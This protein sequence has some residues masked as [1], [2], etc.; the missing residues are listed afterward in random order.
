MNPSDIANCRHLKWWNVNDHS[1]NSCT[2]VGKGFIFGHPASVLPSCLETPP[3]RQP[4][5]EEEEW[6]STHSGQGRRG[7]GSSGSFQ[8]LK[9]DQEHQV[10]VHQGWVHR[11]TKL[12]PLASAQGP[13]LG[14]CCLV[15]AARRELLCALTLDVVPHSVLWRLRSCTLP[16][17]VKY[18]KSW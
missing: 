11:S 14:L 6:C 1:Q 17:S 4:A 13:L 15:T 2:W 10:W 16:D 3:S 5:G 8:G 18:A 12:L 7:G 9:E